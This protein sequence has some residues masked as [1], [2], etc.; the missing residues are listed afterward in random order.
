MG[1]LPRRQPFMTQMKTIKPLLLL[2]LIISS[3]LFAKKLSD[4]EKEKIEIEQNLRIAIKHREQLIALKLLK[5]YKDLKEKFYFDILLWAIQKPKDYQVRG[6]AFELFYKKVT[7]I[8]KFKY[9]LGLTDRHRLIELIRADIKYIKA[10]YNAKENEIKRLLHCFDVAL[11]NNFSEL[12][13]DVIPFIAYPLIDVR[14]SASRFIAKLEDDKTLPILLK[15]IDS[16]RSIDKTY[17]LDTLY[18]IADP[19]FAPV[20]IKALQ[21]SNKSVRYYALK[22][23]EKVKYDKRLRYYLKIVENDL[24][25]EVKVKAIQII[26]E[27]RS[28]S[29]LKAL[30][31]AVGDRFLLVREAALTAVLNYGSKSSTQAISKQLAL[32]TNDDLKLRQIKALLE[33][34]GAGG[35]GGLNKIMRFEPKDEI[36]M[37]AIYA[38]GVFAKNKAINNLIFNLRS[39]NKDLKIESIYA[40]SH[41]KDK[42]IYNSLLEVLASNSSYEIRSAAF[43]SLLKVKDSKVVSSLKELVE[44][45]RLPM[46]KLQM[47]QYR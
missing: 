7:K 3:S 30:Q 9:S 39:P 27:M 46:F 28:A 18:Y 15:L 33:L 11:N 26:A 4:A 24:D 17:A 20:L 2:T 32:E 25:K 16:S 1:E 13:Y 40:L 43:F 23:L 10:H 12:Y 14:H 6:I 37:W 36:R 22:T 19:K 5:K 34:R 38:S 8:S 31:R 29:V 45:E 42:Q 35:M 21:D 47:K 44:R 41:F